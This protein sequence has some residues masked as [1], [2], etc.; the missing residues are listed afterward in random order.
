[1]RGILLLH[2]HDLV[3]RHRD[4]SSFYVDTTINSPLLE[5]RQYGRP[6][7]DTIMSQFSPVHILTTYFA[8]LG[9]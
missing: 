5:H 1:M 8:K 6:S 3:L 9:I 7:L 4:N 2:I